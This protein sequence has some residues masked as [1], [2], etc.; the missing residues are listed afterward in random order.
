MKKRNEYLDLC[1][2]IAII[3]VI[4]G[5]CI[6]CGQGEEFLN[7][8]LFY[9]N[10]LFIFI[11]S[12][13]MPLFM[14]ISGYLFSK[15][16][17]S[18]DYKVIIKS[19]IKQLLIPLVCS[20]FINT[21]IN[22]YFRVINNK[23][24]TLL[25]GL[26][27][28][29]SNFID[30]PWFLWAIWWC[31]AVTLFVHVIFKDHPLLHILGLL[32]T[33]ILPDSCGLDLY[34]FMYPY[35]VLSYYFGYYDIDKIFNKCINSI[36]VK[37]TVCILYIVSIRFFSNDTY[38]YT[39]GYTL[40]GK[41]YL[42][43]LIINIYRFYIGLLGSIVVLYVIRYLKN[44]INEF[45]LKR[46]LHIGKN[47]LGL[48]LISGYIFT[49]ILPRITVSF[50]TINYLAVFVE[51]IIVLVASLAVNGFIKKSSILNKLFLG[52]R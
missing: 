7:N 49:Y 28:I 44:V 9:E 39:S 17:K 52:G 33:F 30:G 34:K 31:S 10:R 6:Q 50:N 41:E 3:L 26:K 23:N 24:I 22:T 46:L 27:K 21:L 5:H 42:R 35:F 12:F 4:V 18:S 8:N 48:Y 32:L 13:H 20:S 47:S 25:W 19:K 2:A 15:T 29:F 16:V 43:Q 36:Y 14:L 38:I 51:S 1:K 11:Y 40:I 37:I 45:V